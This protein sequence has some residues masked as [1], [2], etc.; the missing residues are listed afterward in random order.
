MIDTKG[1]YVVALARNG[2][3]KLAS[4]N[5]TTA[6][7]AESKAIVD[8]SIFHFGTISINAA[9]KTLTFRIE[10]STFPNWD[11]VEQKRTFTL[12]GNELTYTNPG[13]GGGMVTAVWKRAK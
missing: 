7:A 6:T 8:G 12:T 1:R 3:P 2:L 9:D 13:S 4:N 10:T 5:R 11:G